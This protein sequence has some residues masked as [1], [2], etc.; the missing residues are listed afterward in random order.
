MRGATAFA[1]FDYLYSTVSIHAPHAGRDCDECSPRLIEIVFQSTR[2]MRGATPFAYAAGIFG[3]FQST[4][5]MRGATLTFCYLDLYH[6]V[7]IH[8]PHAGRDTAV[9]YS[10]TYRMVSIHAPHA[11]R[12]DG[13]IVNRM[14]IAGFNPRAPCGA[15]LIKQPRQLSTNMFQS[16][17]PMRGATLFLLPILG[18]KGVSIHAPHAGRDKNG[19]PVNP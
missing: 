1:I 19:F 5:P 3:W 9:R 15:R 16:T 10:D 4:R 8:A 11:G 17:R 18:G 14:W 2:P 13:D 7:S 6:T 12:D